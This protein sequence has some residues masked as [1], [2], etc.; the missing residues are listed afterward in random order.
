[1]EFL[2]EISALICELLPAHGCVIIPG[3]GGFITH[4][5]P[6]VIQAQSGKI[7][8]P[9]AETGF[10]PALR[11]N[12]GLLAQ[13]LAQKTNL[14]YP[15]AID[16]IQEF[17]W[18]CLAELNMGQEV[19][20][21]GLGK[22]RLDEYKNFRFEADRN[23]NFLDDAFGLAPVNALPVKHPSKPFQRI[24][25]RP[26][27]SPRLKRK[28]LMEGIRWTVMIMPLILL[29]FYSIYQTGVL[30]GLVSYSSFSGITSPEITTKEN[31]TQQSPDEKLQE[32]YFAAIQW[33]A[34]IPNDTETPPPDTT[35][36]VI[37]F[38]SDIPNPP[39]TQNQPQ[40]DNANISA[41]SKIDL[42]VSH[43][44]ID[45]QTTN[46]L[47]VSDIKGK[48]HLIIGCFKEKA[49]AERLIDKLK[50]NGIYAFEAGTTSG[51][52]TRVSLGGYASRTEAEQA[53]QN[54][55]QQEISEIW[56]SKL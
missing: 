55:S 8:P 35:L 23:A 47:P 4:Y 44:K 5:K 17:S 16:K 51:G 12:D 24:D 43:N 9:T 39:S 45:S 20:F 27:R 54:F 42:P 7:M 36:P 32:D 34:S 50:T 21:K 52:L 19:H 22:L 14:P 40:A 29:A 48:Y 31:P 18:N 28:H 26:E 13:T 33:P 6:A 38:K 37:V 46:S 25:R 11:T 1:M 15:K 2:K 30:E 49:N 41:E 56:I 53:R 3:L 10:N